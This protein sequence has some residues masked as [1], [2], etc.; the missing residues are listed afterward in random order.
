MSD[1][2]LKKWYLD[3]V[4]DNGNSFFG[5]SAELRWHSIHLHFQSYLRYSDQT[6]IHTDSSLIQHSFPILKK[7]SIEWNSKPLNLKGNWKSLC[8]PI[9]QELFSLKDCTIKWDCFQP[10]SDCTVHIGEQNIIRGNGY[11]ECLEIQ[12]AEWR[13]PLQ[14]LRWGRFLNNNISLV[15]IDWIGE[16]EQHLLFWNGASINHCV[17]GDEC[18]F[19]PEHNA[20]LTFHRHAVLKDSAI[21]SPTLKK[22]P[23]LLSVMPSALAQS[24]ETKWLSRGTLKQKNLSDCTGWAIHERV[25]FQ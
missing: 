13:L 4:D 25:L 24:Q 17:I 20:V 22:I 3:C 11:A 1:I 21:L 8:H 14:E 23:G 18:I 16:K 2:S 19:I 10:H 7:D 6:G 9:H 12:L 15:W 5:Y